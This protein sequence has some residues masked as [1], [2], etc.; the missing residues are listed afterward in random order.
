M[1]SISQILIPSWP[2]S[3]IF[4]SILKLKTNCIKAYRITLPNLLLKHQ[5]IQVHTKPASLID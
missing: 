4:R 3:L 1:F 5:I 2:N